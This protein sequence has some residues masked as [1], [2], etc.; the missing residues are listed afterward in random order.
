MLMEADRERINYYN[1]V[2]T[3]CQAKG[4]FTGELDGKLGTDPVYGYSPSVHRPEK[5]KRSYELVIWLK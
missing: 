1:V 2:I 4:A 5:K 3:N